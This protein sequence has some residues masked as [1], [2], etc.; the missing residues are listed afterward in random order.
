METEDEL[1]QI[2]ARVLQRP[3]LFEEAGQTRAPSA[4]ERPRKV[5][6]VPEG[7]ETVK[8]VY[9]EGLFEKEGEEYHP[10]QSENLNQS[11]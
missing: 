8:Q 6:V 7:K 4:K 9:Q 1:G 10:I 2:Y 5:K 3:F 11:F